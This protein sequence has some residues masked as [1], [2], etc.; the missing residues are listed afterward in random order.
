[1]FPNVPVRL[2]GLDCN[3]SSATP[4]C[5]AT[6]ACS[7]IV[8]PSTR[9]V[10][11]MSLESVNSPRAREP[12][13]T[14]LVSGTTSDRHASNKRSSSFA[15]FSRP[16]AKNR[17]STPNSAASS[18]VVFAFIESPFHLNYNRISGD[19]S[20]QK[21]TV[22]RP[23]TFSSCVRRCPIVLDYRLRQQ[24]GPA[25]NPDIAPLSGSTSVPIE[26]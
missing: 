11:S 15:A 19:A 20:V 9:S 12:N 4:I 10:Q 26:T 14:K 22:A 23:A 24:P 1:M 21:D 5:R 7:G 13:T 3:E 8:I 18:S 16:T 25:P 6:S 17:Q 2:G